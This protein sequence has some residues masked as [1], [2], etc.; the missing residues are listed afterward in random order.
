MA[1]PVEEAINRPGAM[2]AALAWNREADPMAPQVLPSGPTARGLIADEPT[3]TPL[4]VPTPRAFHGALGPQRDKDHRLMALPRREQ[5]SDRLALA[6][7]P[8]MDVGPAAFLAAPYGCGL[9]GPFV[10]PAACR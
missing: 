4:R 9:W 2:V 5:E 1:L 6:L 10:A 3:R 7:G 8:Q